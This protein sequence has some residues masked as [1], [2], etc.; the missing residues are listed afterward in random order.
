M[1]FRKSAHQLLGRSSQPY[2]ADEERMGR[3]LPTNLNEA[4]RRIKTEHNSDGRNSSERVSLQD[5]EIDRKII[6]EE[7]R[8]K[9]ENE[10]RKM[11]GG[12]KKELVPKRVREK[13]LFDLCCFQRELGFQGRLVESYVRANESPTSM[14][15]NKDCKHHDS[16]LIHKAVVNELRIALVEKRGWASS[17]GLQAGDLIYKVNGK[18]VKGWDSVEFVYFFES[19]RPLCLTVARDGVS[20][21]RVEKAYYAG[22]NTKA[23]VEGVSPLMAKYYGFDYT[24]CGGVQDNIPG[25]TQSVGVQNNTARFAFRVKD[26]LHKGWAQINGIEA[27]DLVFLK[28]DLGEIC[29]RFQKE[30]FKRLKDNCN[31]GWRTN[32]EEIGSPADSTEGNIIEAGALYTKSTRVR[33]LVVKD[34]VEPPASNGPKFGRRTDMEFSTYIEDIEH[35]VFLEPIRDSDDSVARRDESHSGIAAFHFPLVKKITEHCDLVIKESN[36]KLQSRLQNEIQRFSFF[37]RPVDL[38]VESLMR[39]LYPENVSP[40]DSIIALNGVPLPFLSLLDLFSVCRP[41]SKGGDWPMLATIRRKGNEEE[42][43]KEKMV[44]ENRFF[45]VREIDLGFAVCGTRVTSVDKGGWAQMRGVLV[46]DL[47]CLTDAFRGR[48]KIVRGVAMGR[49]EDVCDI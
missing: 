42:N 7:R 46:G 23:V 39:S 20:Y 49:L 4:I 10:R 26:V 48:I 29:S 35:E 16:G 19:I 34:S 8:A 18:K 21:G 41:I 44:E 15:V 24:P 17:N 32:G 31:C 13:E 27:G 9:H 11:M 25:P 47:L 14:E 45:Y 36:K 43:M 37:E 3:K 30:N 38:A 1:S 22:D 40:G 12:G 5:S 33:L 28:P 6:D 2:L